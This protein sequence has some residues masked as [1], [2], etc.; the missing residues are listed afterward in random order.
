M[1]TIA[2]AFGFE[3]A[4]FVTPGTTPTFSQIRGVT[5]ANISYEMETVEV[6]GDDD[7]LAYWN[8]SQKGTIEITGGLIDLEVY[9]TITGNQVVTDSGPPE[10]SK[11][12]F[13]TDTELQPV[14]FMLRLRQRAKDPD[15]GAAYYRDVYIFR[16]VG[17]IQ[18]A[19]MAHGESVEV[20]IKANMLKATKDEKN[21]NLSEP[22]FGRQ[23]IVA[24]S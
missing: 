17:T 9:E 12:L 22:A 3:R 5:K 19:G 18:P 13:G 23:D 11:I 21:N 10:I 24:V 16:C 7:I 6:K 2:T 14:E 1:P 4:D 15:S 20:N 8:H